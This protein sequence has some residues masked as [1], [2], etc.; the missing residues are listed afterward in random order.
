MS[1]VDEIWG[2]LKNVLDPEMGESI[3]DMGFVND[4]EVDGNQV[5]V[6]L[7]LTSPFCPVDYVKDDVKRT[8]ENLEWVESVDVD[9]SNPEF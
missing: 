6:R 8:I 9:I 4:I 7:T 2:V 1:D 5:C 3:V